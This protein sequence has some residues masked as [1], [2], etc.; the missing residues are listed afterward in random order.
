ME[1]EVR[2][3]DIGTREQTLEQLQIVIA[4]IGAP[5]TITDIVD[6]GDELAVTFDLDLERIVEWILDLS[7]QRWRLGSGIRVVK[8]VKAARAAKKKTAPKKKKTAPKK[9]K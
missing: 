4:S 5:L 1:H 2:I 3:K 6:E 7:P 9:K 8:K